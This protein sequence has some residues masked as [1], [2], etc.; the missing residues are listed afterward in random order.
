MVKLSSGINYA[1]HIVT[2]SRKTILVALTAI[3]VTQPYKALALETVVISSWSYSDNLFNEMADDFGRKYYQ[4]T[5]RRLRVLSKINGAVSQVDLLRRKLR[6]NII[7]AESSEIMDELVKE[8][9]KISPEWKTRFPNE[10]CAYSSPLVFV[11]RRGNPKT[12]QDWSDLNR[13]GAEVMFADPIL[14]GVGR[15]IILAALADATQ[16][17]KSD[18]EVNKYIVSL[19]QN[20]K[21]DNVGSQVIDYQFFNMAVGDVLITYESDAIRSIEQYGKDRFELVYPKFLLLAQFPVA[22]TVSYNDADD[23][24][25]ASLAFINYM[26]SIDGQKILSSNHFRNGVGDVIRV[27]SDQNLPDL[28]VTT[29]NQSF[30]LTG[31]GKWSYFSPGGEYSRIVSSMIHKDF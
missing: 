2:S 23:V 19:L 28:K 6:A 27:A 4:N 8:T 17:L 9:Q 30:G 21:L 16:R 29:V 18:A 1:C 10:S 3:C 11:V 14:S 12:L 26:Y 22:M 13:I 24:N 31:V 15:Y 7:S 20:R 25:K 5:G